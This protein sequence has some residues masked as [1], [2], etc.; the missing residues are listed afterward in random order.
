MPRKI[1]KVINRKLTEKELQTAYEL[2]DTRVKK[3]KLCMR[4]LEHQ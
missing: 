2:S 1:L 4:K 3:S